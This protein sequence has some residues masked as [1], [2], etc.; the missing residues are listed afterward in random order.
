MVEVKK[1]FVGNL[2][3]STCMISLKLPLFFFFL[4][5]SSLVRKPLVTHWAGFDGVSEYTIC[6]ISAPY[7]LS[8]KFKMFADCSSW[9][10]MM[11]VVK[12]SMW[13]RLWFS[14]LSSIA[15]LYL[16]FILSIE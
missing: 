5:F 10:R 9:G 7:I 13:K 16:F 6:N 1:C 11:I 14:S 12:G 8:L 3:P 2:N 15:V 4:S